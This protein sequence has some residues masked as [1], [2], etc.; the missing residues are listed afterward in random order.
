MRFRLS[1]FGLR[2]VAF[3]FAG[4]A[5]LFSCKTAPKATKDFSEVEVFPAA[6]YAEAVGQSDPY[7]ASAEPR[8]A[9]KKYDY[10]PSRTRYHDL[11]H[12]QVEAWFD[13]ENERMNGKA[14]LQLTPFF[15]ATDSL[16]LDAKGMEVK[17]VRLLMKDFDGAKDIPFKYDGMVLAIKLDRIY[18]RDE[19]FE[20][21]IEYATGGKQIEE[22][23]SAAISSDKGIYFINAD[24]KNPYKPRQIWTQGETEATSRWCP[25]IDAPNERTTLEIAMTVDNVYQTLSNGLKTDSRMNPDGTRTDFWTMDQPIAPYLFMMAVG[26]YAVVRDSWQDI[27]VNYYVEPEYAPYAKAI[28]GN[29]PE[30]M[31]FYSNKL[32]VPYPWKKYAQVVVRDFVSGAMENTTATVHMEALQQDNR[33]LLDN[34]YEDYVAH[35]LFHQWFGDYVTCESWANVPLNEAFATYS[36][37]MWKEYK[38]GKDEADLQLE[39]DYGTYL[40]ESIQKR[41]PLF[42]YNYKDP[43]D[44]FDAH[45]YQKGGLVL[46]NL[47]KILGD[48]AFFAGLKRYLTK[49]AYTDVEGCELRMAFEDVCGRDLN[50]FFDQWFLQAGY[51]ELNVTYEYKPDEQKVAVRILQT[52]NTKYVP[53]FQIP[54]E[55]EITTAGRAMRFPV[56]IKTQDTTFVYTVTERPQNVDLDPDKNV[57]ATTVEESKTMENWLYQLQHAKNYRRRSLALVQLASYLDV[58][59]VE[60]AVMRATQDDFWGTRLAAIECLENSENAGAVYLV[61]LMQKIAETDTKAPV[62][63]RALSYLA[64]LPQDS[65]AAF[66]STFEKALNDSSYKCA[67]KA[68]EILYLHKPKETLAAAKKMQNLRSGAVKYEVALILL[69]EKDPAAISFAV[70]TFYHLSGPYDKLMFLQRFGGYLQEAEQSAEGIRFLMDVAQ[71]DTAWFV[72]MMAAR[73][74]SAF[75]DKPEIKTFFQQLKKKEKN[76]E[77]RE[78]YERQF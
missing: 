7:G 1:F 73:S 69:N 61:Q 24:G 77:L 58:T 55:L 54:T 14:R 22:N 13:W 20:V 15:Y 59:E 37:Y 17:R 46:H 49:N 6:G 26:E 30:I 66:I 44:M 70:K 53:I 65:E 29:T 27:E 8:W 12:T 3:L 41:E 57:L 42:R 25:T 23:A 51:P 31:S 74:L 52:Q 10:R 71:Y 60:N 40:M 11:L 48:D 78:L 62:R 75:A 2:A 43:G 16:W 64:N 34:T 9:P 63:L 19:S 18:L 28:F 50:W 39:N 47:R 4:C 32:G 56:S 45:S 68:L 36:E 5:W 35:E 38:Y 76:K 21:S 33:G 67:A 72:R